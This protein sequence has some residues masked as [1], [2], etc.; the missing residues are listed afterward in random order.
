MS[1]HETWQVDAS[2][3]IDLANGTQVSWLR[4]VDEF[5]GA[6]LSTVIFPPRGLDFGPRHGDPNDPPT[7]VH[8]VGTPGADPR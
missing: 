7:D 6:V 4:I 5:S 2:E 3:R 8:P 1:L